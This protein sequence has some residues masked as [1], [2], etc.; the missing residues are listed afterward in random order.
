[1]ILFCVIF[2]AVVFNSHSKSYLNQYQNYAQRQTKILEVVEKISSLNKTNRNAVLLLIDSLYEQEQIDF[3]K[4][5][6][7]FE[8]REE[9]DDEQSI[10]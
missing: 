3:K 10:S 2:I 6:R 7:I 9:E 5:F 8:Y 1:M 4:Q